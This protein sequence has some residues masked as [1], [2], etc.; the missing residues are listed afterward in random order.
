[1]LKTSLY[2]NKAHLLFLLRHLVEIHIE[3]F[4]ETPNLRQNFRRPPPVLPG[5]LHLNNEGS[6]TPLK[7]KCVLPYLSIIT[8][9]EY[10]DEA[11]IEKS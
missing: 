9:S 7:Y 5:R 8:I 4:E 3:I 2:S 6:L 10:K 11:N 1:M